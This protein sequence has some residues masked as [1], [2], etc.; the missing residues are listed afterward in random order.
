MDTAMF[1]NLEPVL[2]E[3]ARARMQQRGISSFAI[4]E[5]LQFGREY[6]DRH[7]GVILCFDRG[8]RRRLLR[9]GGRRCGGV[10][11]PRNVYLV[12]TDG[13]IATVGHRTRRLPRY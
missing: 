1:P 12:E 10:E 4:E 11:Y 5:L 9:A 3:H 13:V 2:T 7:G 6:H 8:A